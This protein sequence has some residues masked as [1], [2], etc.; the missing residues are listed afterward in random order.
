VVAIYDRGQS[1]GING[2]GGNNNGQYYSGAVYVFTHTGA[3]WLQKAYIKASNQDPAGQFGLS[4]LGGSISLSA[5]GNTLAA[6]VRE[7]SENSHAVYVY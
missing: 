2:S 7:T 3:D 4:Q 1:I 6:S 5:D